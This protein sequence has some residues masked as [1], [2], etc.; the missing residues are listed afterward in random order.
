MLAYGQSQ[1]RRSTSCRIIWP[2]LLSMALSTTVV[3][4]Q[5]LGPAMP[6]LLQV[7]ATTKQSSRTEKLYSREQVYFP[8]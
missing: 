8:N 2:T 1:T 4:M 3:N 6:V 5:T 7:H